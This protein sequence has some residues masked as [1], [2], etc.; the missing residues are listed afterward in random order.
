MYQIYE[1]REIAEESPEY[2]KILDDFRADVQEIAATEFN[3]P[4]GGMFPASDEFGETTILP[5]FLA[6][7][8]ASLVT[9]CQEL[10]LT[11]ALF[12]PSA[13]TSPAWID[14]LNGTLDEDVMI[15][16]IGFVIDPCKV[17]TDSTTVD[18]TELRME[19]G[20]KKFPRLNIEEIHGYEQ[21][22]LILEQGA[23]ILPEKPYL[24]RGMIAPPGV[25]I[26]SSA[27]RVVP[28]GVAEWK[29]TDLVIAE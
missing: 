27:Q 6:N 12:N 29:R 23:M 18:V 7:G 17:G 14:I 9:F 4:Y 25:S 11:D 28:I 10:D 24:L 21:P 8:G 26:T 1:A 3:K 22:V 2:Q 13:G 5:K 19:I 15:G 16:I 20:D